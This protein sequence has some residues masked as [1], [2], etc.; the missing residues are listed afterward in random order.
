MSR[1]KPLTV[2]TRGVTLRDF[3]IFQLKLVLDGGIDFVALWLS[4]PAIILDVFAGR[5]KRP[6][7]F[8]SVVRM[9]ERADKWLNL[10]GVVQRMDE[11]ET[12]DGLFGG[13]GDADDD[14]LV[15]EI[16]RLVRR[17]GSARAQVKPPRQPL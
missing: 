12:E 6:R 13:T 11:M 7:L 16:E 4:I 9:S 8:Y 10:H 2:A 5:G 14:N 1:K 17:G 15:S 3:A